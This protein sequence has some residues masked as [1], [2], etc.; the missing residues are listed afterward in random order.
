MFEIS[1][2]GVR[3]CMEALRI[4][5]RRAQAI[6]GI[7]EVGGVHPSTAYKYL[8]LAERLGMVVQ[9]EGKLALVVNAE[10][11]EDCSRHPAWSGCSTPGSG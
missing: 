11:P 6:A 2:P 10:R 9:V 1:W 8:R 3:Y 7:A 5:K 4:P